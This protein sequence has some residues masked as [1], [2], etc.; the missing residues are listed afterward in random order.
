MHVLIFRV[1]FVVVLQLPCW[2]A[3]Q[4]P[5]DINSD[6]SDATSHPECRKACAAIVFPLSIDGEDGVFVYAGK[7]NHRNL[8]FD[9]AYIFDTN[10]MRW[11]GPIVQFGDDLGQLLPLDSHEKSASYLYR[12]SSLPL[13]NQRDIAKQSLLS[14]DEIQVGTDDETP[15]DRWK[16]FSAYVRGANKG[17]IF[18]GSTRPHAYFNDVWCFTPPVINANGS[19]FLKWEKTNLTSKSEGPPIGRRAF[20]G[21]LIENPG[22]KPI[23]A[24]S[25][26]RDGDGNLLEDVWLGVLDFPSITW[27]QVWKGAGNDRRTTEQFTRMLS[28]KPLPRRG[29]AMTYVPDSNDPVLVILGGRTT[30]DAGYFMD[31]WAFHLNDYTW[32]EWTPKNEMDDGNKQYGDK[33]SGPVGRDHFQVV[34]YNKGIYFF[35]GRGGELYN[36]SQPLDDL[37]KFD[38]V[39]KRWIELKQEGKRPMARF[40]AAAHSAGSNGERMVIFGGET[41]EPTTVDVNG[42]EGSF[43]GC[44]LK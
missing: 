31:V 37:W 34:Y 20:G 32:E 29:H 43:N 9:D 13:Q 4:I 25:L 5:Q 27:K 22:Q 8:I 7:G 3:A 42:H 14:I 11:K 16:L 1:L 41:F 23:L 35:G 2:L 33:T 21:A 36:V 15:S 30:N 12:R 19:V 38:V 44:Y 28:S 40:L 18:G 26:G 17:I 10:S 39:N 6:T 24:I